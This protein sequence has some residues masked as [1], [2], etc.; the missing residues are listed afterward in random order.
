MDPAG[1]EPAASDARTRFAEQAARPDREID[2]ASAALWIAAE[3]S[4][5]LDVATYLGTLDALA[6]A[7]LPAIDAAGSTRGA[8]DAL[9]RLLFE[10]Y[11][12]HGNESEYYDPP[13]SFLNDVLDRRCGI[14]ITLSLVF[15][16]V[17]RRA[18]LDARGVGF[19]GH[20]LAKVVA[21]EAKPAPGAAHGPEPAEAA[22]VV[23][24]FRGGRVLDRAGCEALLRS[25]AGDAATFDPRMLRAARPRD[26]LFRLLT[27]L[28]QIYLRSRSLEQA[29]AC[30]DRILLLAPDD[31][32]ERRDRGLV[33]RELECFAPA[34]ADLDCFL[35]ALPRHPTAPAVTTLRD[36]LVQ[37]ARRIH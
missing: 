25:V 26:I 2:V 6:R 31:P 12:L 14:P 30:C 17:A 8:V 18:G 3:A 7:A 36:E 22:I 28:K 10:E 5:G 11:S 1:P 34:L 32:V 23:D 19:P 29:L 20:F 35:E 24:A 4:P 9:R 15:V 33:Y 37:Q 16:E 21:N 27:N 13:N